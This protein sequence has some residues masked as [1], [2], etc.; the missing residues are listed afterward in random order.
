MLQRGM[1]PIME[2]AA[3]CPSLVSSHRQ[4]ARV[5]AL[6]AG[7]RTGRKSVGGASG[8]WRSMVATLS[9]L[10]PNAVQ[11]GEN[12]LKTSRACSTVRVAE[13]DFYAVL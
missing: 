8:S 5:R 11:C 4:Y 6:S 10:T 3:C 1:K 9:S 13:V 7:A 12:R 2:I